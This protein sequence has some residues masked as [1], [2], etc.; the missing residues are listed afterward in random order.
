MPAP[1]GLSTFSSS[2]PGQPAPFM[3]AKL[4]PG[5]ASACVCARAR[6]LMCREGGRGQCHGEPVAE[7]VSSSTLSFLVAHPHPHPHP[8]RL[9]RWAA[10]TWW[11]V[12]HTAGALLQSLGFLGTLAAWCEVWAEARSHPGCRVSPEDGQWEVRE[13]FLGEG[14]LVNKHFPRR[15]ADRTWLSRPIC[16]AQDWPSGTGDVLSQGHRGRQEQKTGEG[17]LGPACPGLFL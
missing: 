5:G 7:L 13:G 2:H 9:R 17:V 6:A 1:T 11:T 4:R 3:D 8:Q 10:A 15:L 14:T 12:W 16:A